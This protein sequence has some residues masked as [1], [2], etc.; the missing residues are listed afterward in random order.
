M[1]VNNVSLGVSADLRSTGSKFYLPGAA[2]F[3]GGLNLG[4]VIK[5]KV[6]RQFDGS[7]RYLVNFEG[8]ERV[9]DSGVPLTTGELIHGRV[10]GLGDRV[11]LQRVYDASASASDNRAAEIARSDTSLFVG[12]HERVVE[13]FADRFRVQLSAGDKSALTRAVRMASDGG[14]MTLAGVMLNKLGLPQAPE[15]LWPVYRALVREDSSSAALYSGRD[16]PQLAAVAASDA[17]AQ[18]TAVRQLAD[19]LQNQL[20][21]RDD[22]DAASP[23]DLASNAK[24]PDAVSP[25][26]VPTVTQQQQDGGQGGDPRQWAHRLLNTQ[27]EGTVAHRIGTVPLLLGNQLI[28]VDLSF[29]EQRQEKPGAA[30]AKHKKV[31]FS[32]RTDRLGTVDINISLVGN[33]ARVQIATSDSE[34]TATA[35][36]YADELRAALSG[37]GWEVD[38]IVYETRQADSQ[39]GVVRSVVDHIISQDSLNRLV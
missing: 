26:V 23:N 30:G 31:V 13:D 17:G 21:Q 35:A 37:I 28:E 18:A 29:F 25:S 10:I 22:R 32:L 14:S 16:V 6:L 9:V 27:T 20:G 24:N 12:R 33:H 11:E 36:G 4:Q 2:D 7:N 15:L 1:T 34:S 8:H 5:G 39:N 38:E 19:L 3:S